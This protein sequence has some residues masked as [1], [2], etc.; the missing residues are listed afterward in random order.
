VQPARRF[1]PFEVGQ[2]GILG[3]IHEDE[4][5][6]AGRETVSVTQGPDG[7][8]A[9]AQGADDDGDARSDARVVEDAP[10]DAGVRGAELDRKDLRVKA[11]RSAL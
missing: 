4:V 8:A 7:G 2:V 5:E 10:R 6:V 11:M 9:V 3:V 1:D